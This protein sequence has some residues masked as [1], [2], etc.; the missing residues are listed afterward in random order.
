[1]VGNRFVLLALRHYERI[2]FHFSSS[3]SSEE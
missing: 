3:G 1:M 2:D